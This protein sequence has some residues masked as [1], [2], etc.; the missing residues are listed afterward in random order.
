MRRRVDRDTERVAA[1]CR[2]PGNVEKFVGGMDQRL[3]RDAAAQQA[4][5]AGPLAVDQ[6]G[7][8]AELAGAD[9]RDI[10]AGS[11]ADDENARAQ[12]FGHVSR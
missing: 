1:A 4:G 11:A 12:G 5:A 7:V 6:H 8:E 2:R 10:A 9:R 3:R